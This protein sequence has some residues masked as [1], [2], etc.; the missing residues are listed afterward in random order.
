M[1]RNPN[2]RALRHAG[3]WSIP[4]YA[5]EPSARRR[6]RFRWWVY[7]RV[8]GGTESMECGRGHGEGLSPRMRGN[9]SNPIQRGRAGR[10]IP[11]YAGEPSPTGPCRRTSSVYPRVCGGTVAIRSSV[12]GPG[13]LSPRMRGNHTVYRVARWYP[14]SIPAYAGEPSVSPPCLRKYRV[15]PRVCGGTMGWTFD[16]DN[17]TGLSP[18]MR[19]NRT[20]SPDGDRL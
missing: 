6:S 4:A 18:R 17:T 16:A 7:P 9:R 13:G 8:C 1:R 12:V 3:G 14:G 20:R 11:A 19:G 15:Y 5:G 2:E 10:S